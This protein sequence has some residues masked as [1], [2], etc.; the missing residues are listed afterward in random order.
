MTQAQITRALSVA[1]VAVAAALFAFGAWEATAGM[2]GRWRRAVT[3]V[4]GAFVSALVGLAI[5][6]TRA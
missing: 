5:E 4:A 2:P 1:S 3:V 6:G